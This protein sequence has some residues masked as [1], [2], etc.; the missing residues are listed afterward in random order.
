MDGGP[1]VVF[2]RPPCVQS[3]RAYIV[4]PYASRSKKK[5][6]G[7]NF[8]E[9]KGPNSNPAVLTD[10]LLNFPPGPQLPIYDF[11]FNQIVEDPSILEDRAIYADT[12][13]IE[14]H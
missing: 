5:I 8:K 9:D 12:Y 10:E 11:H 6:Q 1:R 3:T 14:I 4:C 7:V 2:K 13:N